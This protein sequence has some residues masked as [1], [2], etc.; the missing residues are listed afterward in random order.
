MLVYFVASA[1][2][3]DFFHRQSAWSTKSGVVREDVEGGIREQGPD[4]V[5]PSSS[6]RPCGGPTRMGERVV[7]SSK[8]K[9]LRVDSKF[10][11][12]AS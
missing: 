6:A 7:F 5:R 3:T 9:D 1:W 11:F 12:F 10:Y 2:S 4:L 8:G